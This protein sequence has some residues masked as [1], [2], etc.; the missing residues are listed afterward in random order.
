[1]YNGNNTTIGHGGGIGTKTRPITT[2]QDQIIKIV[3]PKGVGA[4]GSGLGDL[5]MKPKRMSTITNSG[6]VYNLSDYK[7]IPR[8]AGASGVAGGIDKSTALI[9]KTMITLIES[10]V[11]N[12]DDISAIYQLLSTYC[13]NNSDTKSAEIISKLMQERD[14]DNSR[15]EDNLA[16]LKATVDSILAS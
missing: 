8:A 9:L 16:D 5:A 6:R 3:R 7:R 15:I 11:K 1:M 13:A 14:T 2:N 4:S 10:I 12:T